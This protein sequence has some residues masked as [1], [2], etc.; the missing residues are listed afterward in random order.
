MKI[1]N[2]FKLKYNEKPRHSYENLSNMNN[3][4]FQQKIYKSNSYNQLHLLKQQYLI[5][6]KTILVRETK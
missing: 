5:K 2:R 1:S 6:K 3:V 4:V